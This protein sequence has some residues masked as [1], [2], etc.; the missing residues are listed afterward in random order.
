M[1][2]GVEF[3]NVE[4]PNHLLKKFSALILTPSQLSSAG[5]TSR[6]KERLFDGN[7]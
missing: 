7:P 6:K 3:D 1:A 4:L 5:R 2:G